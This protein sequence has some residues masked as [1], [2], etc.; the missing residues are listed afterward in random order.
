MKVFEYSNNTITPGLFSL[1]E[2]EEEYESYSV[3]RN[4]MLP[5]TFTCGQERQAKGERGAETPKG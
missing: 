1:H 5:N 3:S 4:G 2:Q